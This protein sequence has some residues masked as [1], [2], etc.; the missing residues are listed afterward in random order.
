MNVTLGLP[1]LIL[2]IPLLIMKKINISKYNILYKITFHLLYYIILS[3][4]LLIGFLLLTFIIYC[5][6]RHH[7]PSHHDPNTYFLIVARPFILVHLFAKSIVPL[8]LLLVSFYLADTHIKK[9]H[10]YIISYQK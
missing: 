8:T 6:T 4:L 9:F 3:C 1:S 2:L 7:D 10:Q 5:V